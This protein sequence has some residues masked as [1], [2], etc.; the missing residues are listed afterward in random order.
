[1]KL[2]TVLSANSE[3]RTWLTVRSI[4]RAKPTSLRAK[5]FILDFIRLS[6]RLLTKVLRMHNYYDAVEDMWMSTTEKMQLPASSLRPTTLSGDA[7]LCLANV[8]EQYR[9]EL[10]H[11]AVPNTK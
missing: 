11:Q 3:R 10:Q 2:Q 4:F 9:L 6:L 5:D 8:V 1:M 7:K